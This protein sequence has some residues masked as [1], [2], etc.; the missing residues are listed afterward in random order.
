[1]KFRSLCI[2]TSTLLFAAVMAASQTAC[3]VVYTIQPQNTS[4]FGAAI[5][6]ENTGTTNWTSWS[7]TWSFANG[8]TVSQLWNGNATQSGAN[9]TVTNESYNGS[10]N[11]GTSYTGVGFNGTWNGAANTMPTN[12]AVNGVACG[13]SASSSFK[14]SASTSSLS[15]VQ[16]VGGTDTIMVT[17][18]GQFSGSVTLAASG[19]PSGVTATF[20][21]NPATTTSMLTLTASSTAVAG[22]STI[23]I[24]GISGSLSATTSISLTVTSASCTPTAI[25]PYISV[26]GGSTWS[27][28]SSASVTSTSAVVDLGPQPSS[29]G[30]W[31][32]TGPNGFTSTS[33]R[34]NS[35][36]LSAGANVYTATYT[37]ST[38]CK[39][40][41][42][43][44][45]TVSGSTG[46]FT[47]A[48]A[49]SSVTLAQG[50]SATDVITNTF[51]G[52][53]SGTVTLTASSSNSGVTVAVSGE[54][55]TLKAS[56]TA[57]GTA[58][59]NLTGTSG[60]LTATTTIMVTV[61]ANSVLAPGDHDVTITSGGLSR[62]FIVHI[63]TGY[64]GSTE[65]PAIIDFHPLG[66]SGSEQEGL[67]GWEAKCNT[68]GC[69]VAYPDSSSTEASDGSW[70][71]GF[72]CDDAEHNAVND[73]QFGRDIITWL[74]SNTNLDAT[75]V[76][77]S[78]GS[79]GAGMAY[80]MACE[81]S[82]VIAAAAAVDFRCSTGTDPKGN[83][84]SVTASNNTACSCPNLKRPIT[85]VAWDEA[86]DNSLVPYN[87][88][89]GGLPGDCPPN[90][91]CVTNGFT[92]AKVNAQ[93]WADF[94]G[95][96]GSP[97]TDPDN[98]LCQIWTSCQS[99]TTVEL[100]THQSSVHLSTYSDSSANWIG[101]SWTR[102]S[103]QTLP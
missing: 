67:S 63:P 36:A 95:C 94:S 73:V 26:N 9:V 54:T 14:L 50:A 96:T 23:T 81:A 84:A 76:Y 22:T 39:S 53:F 55:L 37:N 19:L 93:T 58:T 57:T 28:T 49:S 100:C 52:G 45:I 62:T 101:V 42:A 83:A 60:S 87:G 69:I 4:A 18:A 13:A 5:T 74:K 20:G 15:V 24:T 88:G 97:T 72:C 46:G 31:S 12:F 82:D 98:S 56:S 103:G 64:T 25:T 3:N 40:T 70:N 38:G 65:T 68:V 51:T 27:E 6:I 16:G 32:W 86:G 61:T 8:Q 1:M 80:T 11:A 34:I 7:L 43:F 90:G 89:L 91:S 92:S 47:I 71:V 66:G 21:T 99:N 85:V 35:I 77:A 78:G 44:T 79:N 59:I 17:D 41:Q 10:I 2:A 29:G 75:R 48:P 33:R 102:L 30:T